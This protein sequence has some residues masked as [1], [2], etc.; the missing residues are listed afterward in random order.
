[1]DEIERATGLTP[2]THRAGFKQTFS[3]LIN[4]SG[5]VRTYTQA[6]QSRIDTA[7][8]FNQ[9]YVEYTREEYNKSLKEL[10]EAIGNRDTA[11]GE[12][13][14][15]REQV[16]GLM[17]AYNKETGAS[18]DVDTLPFEDL[19]NAVDYATEEVG[20]RAKDRNDSPHMFYYMR[21]YFKDQGYRNIGTVTERMEDYIK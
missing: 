11:V 3:T 12:E 20:K 16:R 19:K 6:K 15:F 17:D 2:A 7:K 5:N 21:E 1:M 14:Y 4:S 8:K 9:P 13:N 10:R 18:L